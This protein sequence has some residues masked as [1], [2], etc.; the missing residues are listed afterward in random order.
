M[1][2]SFMSHSYDMVK[3][4]KTLSIFYFYYS[5]SRASGARQKQ[6]QSATRTPGPRS[7]N[8]RISLPRPWAGCQARGTKKKSDFRRSSYYVLLLEL[9]EIISGDPEL[10]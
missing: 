9:L 10:L 7:P 6:R 2:P 4:P 8:L 5:A 3:T 1:L